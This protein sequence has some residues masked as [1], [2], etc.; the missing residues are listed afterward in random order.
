MVTI[1]IHINTITSTYRNR[2]CY[3]ITATMHKSLHSAQRGSVSRT[4]RIR[5]VIADIGSA[6]LEVS[7]A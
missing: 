1:P 7:T 2:L 5:Y 6:Q 4:L 3:G